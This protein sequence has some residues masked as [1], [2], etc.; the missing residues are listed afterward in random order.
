M[1]DNSKLAA[2]TAIITI[3]SN[4]LLALAKGITGYFGNSFALIAD[5]IEST[6][7]VFTSIAVLVG[8]RYA[9]KPPDDNHPYGHGKA[10]PLVTFLIVGFL[11]ASAVLIIVEGIENISNPGPTPEPYTLYVLLGVIVIK[12]GFYRF[13]HKRSKITKSSSLEA[14]AWHSRSDAITSLAAFIGISFSIIMGE[15]YEVADDIAALFAGGFILYNAFLI[16]RPA[17]GE[18]MDEDTHHELAENIRKIAHSIDGI[19]NTEKCW[20]RKAGMSYNID[21]QIRVDAKITVQEGHTIAH[22][23]KDKLQLTHPEI[24]SAHIHVEPWENS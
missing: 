9:S 2:K 11:I 19:I 12:E 14:D 17:L 20:I 24:I 21:I 7:D 3:F 10:E 6:T 5:A 16:F 13:I 23:F 8:I 15:G 22:N 4:I 1:N 18:V